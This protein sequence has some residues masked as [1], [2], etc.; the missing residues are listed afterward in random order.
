MKYTFDFA[1]WLDP[2]VGHPRQQRLPWAL[3][4]EALSELDETDH[5]EGG[6]HE[7][8]DGQE[9][10]SKAPDRGAGLGNESVRG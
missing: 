1:P 5:H 9:D 7:G 3:L 8:Q 4:T 2:K 10:S 6:A